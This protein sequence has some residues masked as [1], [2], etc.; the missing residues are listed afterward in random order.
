MPRNP[1]EELDRRASAAVGRL[2]EEP[3]IWR[4]ILPSAT[5]GAYTTNRLPPPD[6]S[7]PAVE[8]L[9]CIPT[10]APNVQDGAPGQGGGAVSTAA[11]IVDMDMSQFGG[12]RPRKGDHL[13]LPLQNPGERLVQIVRTGDDGS[14]RALYSCQV[15]KQ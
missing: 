2:L 8:G 1:F 13:E 12:L 14:A 9:R 7:R 11:L 15:V 5:S 10:W 6:P 4:P 3:C